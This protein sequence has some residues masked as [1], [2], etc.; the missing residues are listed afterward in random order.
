MFVLRRFD[1]PVHLSA[2]REPVFFSLQLTILHLYAGLIRNDYWLQCGIPQQDIKVAMRLQ[3]SED[4]R[5]F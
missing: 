1:A 5:Y 3:M 4:P 2:R